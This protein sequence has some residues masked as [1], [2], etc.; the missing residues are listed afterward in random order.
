MIVDYTASRNLVSSVIDG[1]I[2]P[3]QIYCISKHYRLIYSHSAHYVQTT[4]AASVLS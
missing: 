4:H 3:L 1:D 2:V